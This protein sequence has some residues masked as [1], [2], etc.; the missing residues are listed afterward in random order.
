MVRRARVA[1]V[2]IGEEMPLVL[3]AGPCVIESERAVLRL[4]VEI[5]RIAEAL[6]VPVIFKASF[7]KANRTSVASYRGPGLREGLRIL[8]RVRRE[9]GLPVT[10]DIHEPSQAAPAAK[11]LDLLQ[12]PALLCRQTDLLTA[13][14]VTGRPVNVKKGQFMAPWDMKRVVE[15]LNRAGCRQVLLTE[16]G[17]TLGYNNLVSDMRA[18][19]IMKGLGCPVVY[20][21]THSVQQPGAMGKTSG[22]DR[23]MV[24]PLAL[25]AVAAGCDALFIETHETPAKGLSDPATMLPLSR[26]GPLLEKAALIHDAV[27]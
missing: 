25:A 3:I 6:R 1:D 20:D 27:R 11:A 8:A 2:T 15:K 17:T 19:P 7:D 23:A 18:I 10:S 14:A 12:I 16:R 24:E 5:R 26:L 21:A 4:A 13:A 9:T 22:G